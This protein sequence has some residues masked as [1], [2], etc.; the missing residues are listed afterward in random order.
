[1][2]FYGEYSVSF[3]GKG[4]IVLPKKIRQLLKGNIFILSKGFNFYLAGYD[5]KDWEK[6]AAEFMNSS[7]LDEENLEKKRLLFSSTSYIDI[8]KQGRFIIPQNL[9]EYAKLEKKA[10]IIGVGD[11]FEI[12]SKKLWDK[13]KK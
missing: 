13:L 5:K 11:H 2:V 3:T 7:L 4:R 8:D 1:M 9:L 6:K 12:W 10:A